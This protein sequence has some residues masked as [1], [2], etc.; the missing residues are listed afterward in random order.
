[1]NEIEK[2]LWRRV[3]R[4]SFVFRLVPFVRMVG[5]CNSLSFG[6]VD[7]HSDIDLFVVVKR[8]RLFIVR[9][10]MMFFFQILGVRLHG[11][12]IA[13]RFC[14]SFFVDDSSLNLEPIAL[15]GDIYLAYWIRKMVVVADD[16]LMAAQFLAN[17]LWINSYFEE[18]LVSLFRANF[19]LKLHKRG[20]VLAR[21]LG[22]KFGDRLEA[23]L[24]KWQL[25]RARAKASKFPVGNG[26]IVSE[27]MLKFH[28]HELR[29]RYRQLWLQLFGEDTKITDDRFLALRIDS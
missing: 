27:N 25:K 1:M 9:S 2:K 3:K 24:M 22:G 5:V 29:P 13:G 18:D 20:G 4:F 17:N 14:L 26:I 10:L 21:F 23:F 7:E 11:D 8:G 16:G 12:K 28:H 6:K 19:A 15:K